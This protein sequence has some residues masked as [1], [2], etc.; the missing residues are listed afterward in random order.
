[1]CVPRRVGRYPSWCYR[2]RGLKLRCAR[3]P[4]KERAQ[5]RHVSISDLWRIAERKSAAASNE[6]TIVSE[7]IFCLL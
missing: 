3:G 7:T 6:P 5:G 4:V 1:M 2:D